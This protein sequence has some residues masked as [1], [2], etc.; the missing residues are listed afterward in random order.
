MSGES[1]HLL[2]E[3]LAVVLL[4]LRADVAAGGED[5]AVLAD[6]LQR[7]TLAEAGNVGVLARAILAALGVVSIGDAGDVVVGQL[8]VGAVHHAP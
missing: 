7:R 5:V 6:L 1:V 8:P 2:L 4:R 3:G